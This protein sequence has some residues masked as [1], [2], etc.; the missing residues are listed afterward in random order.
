MKHDARRILRKYKARR[1]PTTT[2]NA[3]YRVSDL[4]QLSDDLIKQAQRW[5]YIV[6]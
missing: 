4:T 5:A 6:D 2:Y 3:A 1:K